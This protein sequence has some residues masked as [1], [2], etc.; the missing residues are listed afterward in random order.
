[1]ILAIP[2]M[3][4]YSIIE[5]DF[6]IK[7]KQ[8]L[9]SIVVGILISII[10]VFIDLFFTSSFYSSRYA[11]FPNFMHSLFLEIVI[12]VGICSIFIFFFI[13]KDQY[14][15]YQ[16][17]FMTL[18]FLAIYIPATI[19][20]ENAVYNWYII[21]SKPIIMLSVLYGIK[22]CIIF[23]Y[24]YKEHF[25]KNL[26]T[27]VKIFSIT[28]IVFAYILCLTGAPMIDSAYVLGIPNW[29]L[30]IITVFYSALICIGSLLATIKLTPKN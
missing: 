8:R 30:A 17:Y 7:A 28:G 9:F 24:T 20:N 18:G 4:V 25:H 15:W 27:Q 16:L 23:S 5:K 19:L 22:N 2:T 13:K 29:I 26:K 12:P 6:F 3:I 10:Y 21:F 11:F 14:K 1:M